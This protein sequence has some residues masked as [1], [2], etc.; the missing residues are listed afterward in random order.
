[1]KKSL[2][3]VVYILI[4]IVFAISMVGCKST[5]DTTSSLTTS[6]TVT[7]ISSFVHSEEESSTLDK[8]PSISEFDISSELDEPTTTE[9]EEEDTIEE[10]NVEEPAAVPY[11]ESVEP[12][13]PIE[14]AETIEPVET[15]EAEPV[16]EPQEEY[17]GSPRLYEPSDFSWMGVLN[18]GGYRWTYYS[19]RV[20]P[21][22]G[23]NIPGRHVDGDGYVCD[24]NGYICLAS[25]SLAWG[26]VVDT[27]LGK[28]GCVYDCGP[29][30]PDI[31]DVY[32]DW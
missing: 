24:E 15:I 28:P 25:D 6:E 7:E 19:Q 26:T 9:P 20:L 32:V 4:A 10:E 27:P 21:G 29:G 17:V 22:G 2:I 16:E 18:W 8:Q 13:E 12:V 5:D 23:L 11:E 3:K 14:P 31:L 30:A 1:M